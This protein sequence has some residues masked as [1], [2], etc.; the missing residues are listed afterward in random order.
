MGPVGRLIEGLIE[1]HGLPIDAYELTPALLEAFDQKR[2]Q[3]ADPQRVDLTSLPFVTID[4][5]NAKDFDD[6]NQPGAYVDSTAFSQKQRLAFTQAVLEATDK[7]AKSALAKG[8][9]LSAAYLADEMA[10][11]ERIHIRPFSSRHPMSGIN[12]IL[13]Q[14]RAHQLSTRAVLEPDF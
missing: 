6:A 11:S 13:D 3:P 4:G 10:L 8:L 12:E 14:A 7:A 1:R 2:L 9:D 5:E